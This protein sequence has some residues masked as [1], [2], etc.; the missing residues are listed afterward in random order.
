[1]GSNRVQWGLMGSNGV[2]P[3]PPW[4]FQLMSWRSHLMEW[5]SICVPIS[6]NGSLIYWAFPWP[7]GD[8]RPW[9]SGA[10]GGESGAALGGS[11][12]GLRATFFATGWGGVGW[13]RF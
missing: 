12:L 1:M 9:P 8:A 11:E 13:E 4:R 10:W 2:C 7:G 6:W 3:T 5:L